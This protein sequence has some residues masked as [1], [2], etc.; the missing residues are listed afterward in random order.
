MFYD[1]GYVNKNSWDFSPDRP[2]H[3]RSDFPIDPNR[4]DNDPKTPNPN[5]TKNDL[6]N[7]LF[8]GGL[9]MDIGFGVRLD[10]PIGPIRLDYGYPLLSDD[11]NKRVSGKFSF[12]VGYQ[13]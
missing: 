6:R 12:N 1:I 2:E 7:Q 3:R 13:F 5:P 9:M 8:G 10:L 11:F 4:I